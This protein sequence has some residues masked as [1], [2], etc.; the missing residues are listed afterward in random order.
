MVERIRLLLETRQLT[1]TQ[2]AD[3]IGIARPIVS[4]ILS[5]RN[6]P[7][8]EV[9]QRILASLPDL[10][11]SWLL[12]GTGPMLV[13]ATDAGAP[14]ALAAR[15]VASQVAGEVHPA[16][17]TA[18]PPVPTRVPGPSAGQQSSIAPK[19]AANK[20]TVATSA[21]VAKRFVPKVSNV[22]LIDNPVKTE[23]F[24]PETPPAPAPRVSTLSHSDH[25]P[26]QDTLLASVPL[27]SQQAAAM[28]AFTPFDGLSVSF[29]FHAMGAAGGSPRRRVPSILRL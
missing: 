27:A 17:V 10:S 7:S 6:K 12:N 5:G 11:M 2:F 24:V 9:V 23:S 28:L 29:H 16:S 15:P 19:V 3:T 22:S 21:P 13:P 26:P 18:P 14:P 20:S 25:V 1:P 8:L 4:H